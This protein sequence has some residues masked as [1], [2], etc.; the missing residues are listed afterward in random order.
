MMID[1]KYYKKKNMSSNNNLVW[2]NKLLFSIILVL[3]CLIGS[4]FSSKFNSLIKKNVLEDSFNFSKI[5]N[6]Y[7]K[8]IGSYIDNDDTV[9]VAN[10]DIIEGESVD[11]SY[12]YNI[13]KDEP[14]SLKASGIIVYIGDKDNLNDTVI[15]Q[16]NDGVDIWYSNILISDYS[17]YDYVKKGEVLGTS[18]DNKYY[19]TIM[20]D[21][22]K[23]K[24]EEY[25]E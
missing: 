16:G 13:N 14:I 21:G 11:G 6:F 4:N 19:L 7:N 3:I 23:L 18:L 12:L 2:L 9:I 1:S 8:F 5:N 22:K 24:Y 10:T 15:V 20:K 17:L 25:F